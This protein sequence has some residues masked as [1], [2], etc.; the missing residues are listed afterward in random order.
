M[1]VRCK[2]TSEEKVRVM[3]EDFQ[4]REVAVKDRY[5]RE[6]IK[7]YY[8]RTKEIIP[9]DSAKVFCSKSVPFR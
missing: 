1:A 6:G 9:T 3:L 4:R 2:Y 8:S 5:R 7:V